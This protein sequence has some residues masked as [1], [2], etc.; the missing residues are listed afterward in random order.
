MLALF[1]LSKEPQDL[2]GLVQDLKMK[3]KDLSRS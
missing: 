1:L 3:D 2:R